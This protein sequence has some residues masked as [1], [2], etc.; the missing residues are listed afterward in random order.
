[1]GRLVLCF[2]CWGLG[3]NI[4][5]LGMKKTTLTG[6]PKNLKTDM[7]Y[8]SKLYKLKAHIIPFPT[9]YNMEQGCNHIHELMYQL[10]AENKIEIIQDSN[11]EQKD[12]LFKIKLTYI[13]VRCIRKR[14]SKY[15]WNILN[16]IVAFIIIFGFIKQYIT[17]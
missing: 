15:F 14:R 4:N 5:N 13:G 7:Q 1:L 10:K 6:F 12:T 11:N 3:K 16:L 9:H 17:S 8:I 2:I